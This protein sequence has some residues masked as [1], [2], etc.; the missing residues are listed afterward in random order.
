MGELPVIGNFNFKN[1]VGTFEGDDVNNGRPVKVRYIWSKIT[2][3]SAHWEQALSPDSGKTW[4]T[5]W[6]MQFTRV[7]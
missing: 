1:G 3:H 4:E 7:E 6:Q 5:N 2:K